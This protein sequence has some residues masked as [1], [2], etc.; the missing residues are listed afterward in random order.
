M[1]FVNLRGDT[2]IFLKYFDEIAGVPVAERAHYIGN[3][4]IGASQ[5]FLCPVDFYTVHKA[6]EVFADLAGEQA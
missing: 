4:R 3:T 5:H 2:F 6:S 1:L